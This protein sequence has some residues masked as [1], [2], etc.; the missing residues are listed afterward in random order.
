MLN[1]INFLGLGGLFGLILR[2][3]YYIW[4]DFQLLKQNLHC[5]NESHLSP[6]YNYFQV[7]LDTVCWFLFWGF[8]CWIYKSYCFVVSWDM[9]SLFWY[10]CN[11]SLTKRIKNCYLLWK[12]IKG[13]Y[14]FYFK[15]LVELIHPAILILTK[16]YY[17]ILWSV[18]RGHAYMSQCT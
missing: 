18:C 14:P 15:G 8:S 7:L 9:L 12:K 13:S 10:K 6:V 17:G 16:Y 11:S 4:I 3:Q 2:I 1:L 5:W